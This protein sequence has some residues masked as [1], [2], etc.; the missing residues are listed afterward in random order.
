MY[1]GI[2]LRFNYCIFCWPCEA[3]LTLEYFSEVQRIGQFSFQQQHHRG[4]IQAALLRCQQWA[5]LRRGIRGPVTKQSF[6]RRGA[7]TVRRVRGAPSRCETY[8]ATTK[9]LFL[10]PQVRIYI[11]GM[12]KSGSDRSQWFVVTFTVLIS[13][14][15]NY[16]Y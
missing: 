11:L 1:S 9:T 2:M 10:T 7:V 15:I 6:S 4:A 8:A 13:L 14:A 5:R 12:E 16:N 3:R